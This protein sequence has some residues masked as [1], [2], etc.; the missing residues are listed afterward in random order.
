MRTLTIEPNWQDEIPS[1]S[2][3]DA[4]YNVGPAPCDTCSFTKKCKTQEVECKA[5]RVWVNNGGK[6]NDDKRGHLLRSIK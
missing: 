3:A 6:W 1:V 5:F 2:L 4:I